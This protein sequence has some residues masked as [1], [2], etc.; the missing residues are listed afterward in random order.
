MAERLDG[1]LSDLHQRG[2]FD[3]AVVVGAGGEVL[4]EGAYGLANAEAD[5]PF[6]PDTPLDGGSLAK[7]F[8]AELVLQLAAEGALELDAP[9]AATLPE[10]PYPR[11]TIRQLLSHS[12]GLADLGA[13]DDLVAPGEV[14]TTE[15]HLAL[16]AEHRP[17]LLF[18]PGTAFSYSTLAYDLLALATGRAAGS[19]YA[20][21][22]DER[23][24]RPLGLRSA[25]LR[26]A[27]LADFPGTRT[28]GY[29]RT[30]DGHTDND[31]LDGEAF[32]G[33]SNLYLSV[34]DMQRWVAAYLEPSTRLLGG[35]APR[36]R[37]GAAESGLTLGS[38]YRGGGAEW[39]SGHHQ[40]FHSEAFRR[41][42]GEL[43]IAYGSNNT[44]EPWLM[45]ALVR[46]I[47]EAAI[48]GQ[49]SALQPP[50]VEP[51]DPATRAVLAGAW[52]LPHG[53][54]LR[55][56]AASRAL[57][58][59]ANGV[60]YPVY[61]VA[62]EWFYAPG[63]DHVLGFGGQASGWDRIYLSTNVNEGWGARA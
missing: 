26:P 10:L 24:L 6:T 40:G 57:S 37:I 55:I 33:G 28:R 13:L 39:Y 31:A 48:G 59:A 19:T 49:P 22:L 5:V 44:L 16:L 17:A 18:E 52:Q 60:T 21:L 8:T 9:L 54:T 46:A 41:A 20:E 3:G 61:Q 63:L 38:W 11:L 35:R 12:S 27:R 58:M 56:S 36:A 50:A 47:A 15:T 29:A 1:L 34:R 43:A 25:F 45:R 4:F 2:L 62:L 32:H 51:V 53:P 23:L 30:P 42:D 14:R 7:P